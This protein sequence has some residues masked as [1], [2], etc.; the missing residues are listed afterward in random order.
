MS[1]FNRARPDRA[2]RPY[3]HPSVEDL[4]DDCGPWPSSRSIKRDAMIEEIKRLNE[5]RTK[6]HD[7]SYCVFELY[8]RETHT[9]A[10]CGRLFDGLFYCEPLCQEHLTYATSIDEPPSWKKPKKDTYH[11]VA[12]SWYAKFGH[13]SKPKKLVKI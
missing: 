7:P 1:C 9:L 12:R 2:Y 6:V 3:L 5:E 11:G 4:Y 10:K 8:D 13:F